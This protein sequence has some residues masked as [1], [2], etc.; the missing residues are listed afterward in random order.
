MHIKISDFGSAKMMTREEGRRLMAQGRAAPP[1]DPDGD[2][3]GDESDTM[4]ESGWDSDWPR[5]DRH[6]GRVRWRA[7]RIRSGIAV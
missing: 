7:L 4:A 3:D 2:G 1:A 5:S 6:G